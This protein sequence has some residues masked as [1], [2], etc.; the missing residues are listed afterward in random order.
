VRGY[1][2]RVRCDGIPSDPAHPFNRERPGGSKAGAE[3]G[4]RPLGYPSAELVFASCCLRSGVSPGGEAARPT[5]QR[6]AIGAPDACEGAHVTR[7][8]L[9]RRH[10]LGALV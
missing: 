1:A 7:K 3:K 9:R 10:L 5:D 6:V 2:S 8:S 4:E